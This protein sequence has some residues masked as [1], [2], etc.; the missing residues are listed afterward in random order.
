MQVKGLREQN[1][2]PG[3]AARPSI[4]E[5]LKSFGPH[6]EHPCPVFLDLQNAQ[7]D[8]PSVAYTLYFGILGHKFW[9]FGGPIQTDRNWSSSQ[10]VV[11][12]SFFLDKPL[13]GQLWCGRSSQELEA[14]MEPFELL[15]SVVAGARVRAAVF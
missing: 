3:A 2:P 9:H 8:R 6:A 13:T 7:N 4:L 11:N 1:V 14:D 15:S 12:R 5:A 10:A